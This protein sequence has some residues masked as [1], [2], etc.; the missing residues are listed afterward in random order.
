MLIRTSKMLLNCLSKQP[1]S[2]LEPLSFKR[3]SNEEP[4]DL[5]KQFENNFEAHEKNTK[6]SGLTS[7]LRLFELTREDLNI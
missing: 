7:K 6:T 1:V 2:K 5:S 3:T 4:P